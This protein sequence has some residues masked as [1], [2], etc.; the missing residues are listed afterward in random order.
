MTRVAAVALAT[1]LHRCQ[2][3]LVDL[4]TVAGHA[5]ADAQHEHDQHVDAA[6]QAAA[7]QVPVEIQRASRRTLLDGADLELTNREYN[8]LCVLART[9][10]PP[11]ARR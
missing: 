5:S 10:W 8:L 7:A 11:G 9:W 3:V 6:L 2:R 4:E 1:E